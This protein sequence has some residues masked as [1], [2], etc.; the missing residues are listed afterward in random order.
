MTTKQI[1]SFENISSDETIANVRSVAPHISQRLLTLF[2]G[3]MT[4]HAGTKK[5]PLYFVGSH[6]INSIRTTLNFGTLGA[7]NELAKLNGQDL[8]SKAKTEKSKKSTTQNYLNNSNE[9]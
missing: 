3:A 7:F 4:K 8:N 2:G 1:D 6:I 9:S 5:M